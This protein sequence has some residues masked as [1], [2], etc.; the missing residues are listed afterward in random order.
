MKRSVN[1][2]ILAVGIA[3]CCLVQGNA[4]AA[5]ATFDSLSEGFYGQEL[6]D[7]GIRFFDPDWYIPGTETEF[8]IDDASDNL[9]DDPFFSS[10]NGM[11]MGG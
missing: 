7:G 6:I 5:V 3:A 9:G 2:C 1:G 4:H 10:P 11:G 8:A